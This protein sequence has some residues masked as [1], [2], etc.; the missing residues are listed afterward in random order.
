MTYMMVL[1]I[2]YVPV[3]VPLLHS[4]S[5][6]RFYPIP[7]RLFS[8]LMLQKWKIGEKSWRIVVIRQICQ[9]FFTVRY[10]HV[11]NQLFFAWR[12]QKPLLTIDTSFVDFSP[13]S[14]G[15]EEKG[16]ERRIKR[17]TMAQWI[18]LLRNSRFVNYTRLPFLCVKSGAIALALPGLTSGRLAYEIVLN[19]KLLK[20]IYRIKYSSFRYV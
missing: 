9:S 3:L 2:L 20:I 18:N 7:S 11:C 1:N 10:V 8:R 17:K 6:S 14:K 5:R 13:F 19:L 12:N 15:V 4:M 16:K